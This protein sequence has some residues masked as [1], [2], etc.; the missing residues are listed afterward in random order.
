[1]DASFGEEIKK[2]A[3]AVAEHIVADDERRA[4]L[5]APTRR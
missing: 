5:A 3:V 2:E 4:E 1:M